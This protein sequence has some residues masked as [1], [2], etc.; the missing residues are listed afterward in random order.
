YW[1]RSCKSHPIVPYPNNWRQGLTRTKYLGRPLRSLRPRTK[2]RQCVSPC[3][4]RPR[5]ALGHLCGIGPMS[6]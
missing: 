6:R 3:C 2:C 5:M 4:H 1:L